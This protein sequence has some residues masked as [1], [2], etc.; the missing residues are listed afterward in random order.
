MFGV[1][2]CVQQESGFTLSETL[3]PNNYTKIRHTVLSTTQLNM[4]TALISSFILDT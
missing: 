3:I 2:S 4:T 1:E